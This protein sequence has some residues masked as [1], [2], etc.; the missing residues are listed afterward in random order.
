M[1]NSTSEREQTIKTGGESLSIFEVMQRYRNDGSCEHVIED[2]LRRL[3][4]LDSEAAASDLVREAYDHYM[5]PQACGDFTCACD[6]PK[7]CGIC[8]IRHRFEKWLSGQP[9]ESPAATSMRDLCVEKVKAMAAQDRRFG[10]EYNLIRALG[11][12]L[13]VTELESLTLEATAIETEDGDDG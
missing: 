12:D 6:E 1:T 9:V 11:Y 13:V 2:A 8:D 4:L 3:S 5:G 10:A 7:F